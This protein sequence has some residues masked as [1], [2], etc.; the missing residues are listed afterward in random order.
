MRDKSRVKNND[1]E[2]TTKRRKE[3]RKKGVW[4]RVGAVYHTME[5]EKRKETTE[6]D[7]KAQA[8]SLQR[9]EGGVD[10]K[11]PIIK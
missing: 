10:S 7:R 1:K 9:S 4:R 2:S 8:A 3:E 6:G 5:D 11:T